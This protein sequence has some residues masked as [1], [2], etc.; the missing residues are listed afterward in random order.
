MRSSKQATAW[1]SG[2]TAQRN[3]S[4]PSE[5]CKSALLS[6]PKELEQYTKTSRSGSQ[7]DAISNSI[8]RLSSLSLPGKHVP[9]T[10]EI[11]TVIR[12]LILAISSVHE[13]VKDDDYTHIATFVAHAIAQDQLVLRGLTVVPTEQDGNHSSLELT[14]ETDDGVFA[15]VFVFLLNYL[16]RKMDSWNTQPSTSEDGIDSSNLTVPNNNHPNNGDTQS[17]VSP[18]RHRSTHAATAVSAVVACLHCLILMVERSCAFSSRQPSM[19]PADPASVP[20]GT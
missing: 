15:G 11:V 14:M 17:T 7:H 9:L 3:N 12:W 1:S 8:A 20:P 6:I 13:G 18:A 2:T 5:S 16:Q 10:K 4:T 19:T